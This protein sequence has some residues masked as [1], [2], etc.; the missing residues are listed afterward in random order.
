[1]ILPYAQICEQQPGKVRKRFFRR[2]RCSSDQAS[3]AAQ[4][5]RVL[6]IEFH[7]VEAADW[8]TDLPP[9]RHKRHDAGGKMLAAKRKRKRAAMPRNPKYCG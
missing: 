8:R 4:G 5:N 1:L 7:A 6:G 9:R 2:G 3:P